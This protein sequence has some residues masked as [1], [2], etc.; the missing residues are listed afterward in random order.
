MP[1]RD[2]LPRRRD[3]LLG[4]DPLRTPR[5]RVNHSLD[6]YHE[7]FDEHLDGPYVLPIRPVAAGTAVRPYGL[8]RIAPTITQ[9]RRGARLC[10]RSSRGNG[11]LRVR[12]LEA[13]VA[14]CERRA[15]SRGREWSALALYAGF[16]PSLPPD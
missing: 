16:D 15:T 1:F 2:G 6:W 8:V 14:G 3:D 4:I 5:L 7:L 11:E 12:S 9:T 13:R 10:A